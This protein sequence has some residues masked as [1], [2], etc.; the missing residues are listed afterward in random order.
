M[1]DAELT[2]NYASAYSNRI[3]FGKK[4]ALVLVDF[5]QA[6]FEPDSPLFAGVDSALESALRIRACARE[7]QIPVILTGVVLHPSGLDGG[8]FFQKAKPLSCFTAGNPLGAWPKGLEPFSDEF[9]VTKQYPSAFFGTSL[10]PMLAVMGVD[11]VILTG[12]T[13][14]GCVRASCVDA[15]SHGFITTV[16]RDACGD[17]HPAPHEANLFDMNAKY[18]D[19]ISEAEIMAFIASL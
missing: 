2:A 5:V 12:L 17:R 3:G 6:Y 7:K 10:A 19:V 15:M 9:V 16:V 14:S 8:R 18:A 4:P 11:N 1:S 13:T